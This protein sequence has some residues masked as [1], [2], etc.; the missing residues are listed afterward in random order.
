MSTVSVDQQNV[1][2]VLDWARIAELFEWSPGFICVLKGPDHV[3]EFVNRN[4]RKLFQSE[5]W[6]GKPARVAVP[7]VTAQGFHD[8]LDAVYCSGE[9]YHGTDLPVTYRPTAGANDVTIYHDFIYEPIRSA[10][11]AVTGI[12]CEGFDIA[13]GRQARDRLER[14]SE[15]QVFRLELE[16]TLSDTR[17]VSDCM[18]AAARLICHRWQASQVSFTE[19]TGDGLVVRHRYACERDRLEDEWTAALPYSEQETELLRAG[20]PLLGADDG[21]GRVTLPRLATGSLLG[22]IELIGASN[23][24]DEE[25][26]A[27]L[28]EVGKRIWA[29]IDRIRAEVDRERFFEHSLDL[30]CV[31]TLSDLRI[32]RASRSFEAVLGWAPDELLGISSLD[33][34][35]PDEKERARELQTPL[36]H[37]E[38]LRA[39]EQRVRC[40]DGSYRWISWSSVAVP[41]ENL[42]YAVGRD[43]TERKAFDRQRDIFAAELNHRV[44]NN[45]AVV[46]ALAAETFRS[47]ANGVAPMLDLFTM[48][49]SSLA[50]VHDLLTE[51]NWT[52]VAIG[53]VFAQVVKAAGT[54]ERR[55]NQT[56]PDLALTPRQAIA[57]ALIAN[58]LILNSKNGG[59]LS[60]PNGH[61]DLRWQHDEASFQLSWNEQYGGDAS[62]PSP[63][64]LSQRLLS[65]L[66]SDLNGSWKFDQNPDGV[67]YVFEGRMMSAGDGGER[68]FELPPKMPHN[69]RGASQGP[70]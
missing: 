11:G 19:E 34:I 28:G 21:A 66:A 47:Q 68:T 1:G 58:E 30:L 60:R 37:G 26:I 14:H 10:D 20:A 46:R 12:L 9:R 45:L 35:H 57:A 43:V 53:D 62:S 6:V 67:S 29:A 49:I 5:D 15:R 55:I 33:L 13:S 50:R 70:N 65:A 27:F 40:K 31:A 51:S 17:G 23:P 39:F 2:T 42:L 24:I 38:P 52:T 25:E 44:K 48:R 69:D 41:Q 59:A 63:S 61:V 18:L 8:L 7:S 16:Q 22:C 64:G 4:H 54:S 56:G 32:R 3:I 36:G